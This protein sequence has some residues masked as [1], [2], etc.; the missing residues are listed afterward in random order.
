MIWM[1]RHLPRR[2]W[3]IRLLMT[4]GTKILPL[5]VVAVRVVAVVAVVVRQMTDR[6]RVQSPSSRRPN[7]T[8][9]RSMMM[10][11]DLELDWLLHVVH[12]NVLPAGV[13]REPNQLLRNPPD[14]GEEPVTLP[15]VA[16]GQVPVAVNP[17]AANPDAVNSVHL[18]TAMRLPNERRGPNAIPGQQLGRN[19]VKRSNQS[20]KSGFAMIVDAVSVL[21]NLRVAVTRIETTK[22]VPH[23]RRRANVL[24]AMSVDPPVRLLLAVVIRKRPP[25]GI[26]M[27][28]IET[29]TAN[30]AAVAAV[31]SGRARVLVVSVP[32]GV[33]RAPVRDVLPVKDRV[34]QNRV[35]PLNAA[36]DPL[37]P[38]MMRPT[39]AHAARF[40]P[41]KCRPG[42]MRSLC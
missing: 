37:S 25:I 17:V 26:V 30:H 7:L 13:A 3:M 10:T 24:N 22:L 18:G 32:K 21:R 40:S 29:G 42:N 27:I 2:L 31:K 16:T 5:Q 6:W 12:L 35:G 33:G 39:I 15:L 1:L 36:S 34:S 8:M 19:E 11:M 14:E 28:G 23:E 20:V 41:S 38:S 4:P 9:F